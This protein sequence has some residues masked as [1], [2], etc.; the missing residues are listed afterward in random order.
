[1]IRRIFIAFL[2]CCLVILSAEASDM[3]GKQNPAIAESPANKNVIVAMTTSI[4]DSGLLDDLVPAIEKKTGYTLKKVAVG[5][6]QAL[7]LAE[8][9]EV[10]ALFVNSPKA[11]RKV[12][13]G[14]AVTNRHLVMHNDFVIVGPDTDKAKIRGKKSA[15]EAFS[16][17]AKNQ[18]LFV[19]RGDDSG[20]NKLEK[21]LWQQAKVTP[22]GSWYQQTG[23]G[24]AQTLQVANQKL[25]Y[26]LA[27][28]ATYIF[29]KKNLSLP[30]LVQGDKKLLNL[31]HVM[32]VN[33]QKFPRVN[34][35]GAKA[36]IN[37]VLS[38][39]GQ[40]LIAAHGKKEFKQPLFYVD[41]GKTEKDYGF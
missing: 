36:F 5:T 33:S 25:G 21:D 16:L 3:L 24:M 27:D 9:G 22:S 32:E 23:S 11:E 12:L 38:P 31:Y 41:G 19:S 35:A 17:I 26:T 39:E 18:A 1:M 29:Q 40:T 15:V 6:G 10:D 8:K 30:V 7:A 34:S 13:A 2:A 14:G 4:E 20:T 28:R 37:Y